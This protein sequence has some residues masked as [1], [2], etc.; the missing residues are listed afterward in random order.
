LLEAVSATSPSKKH[1]YLTQED[2][3]VYIPENLEKPTAIALVS[4][5]ETWSKTDCISIQN[6]A[7]QQSQAAEDSF[8]SASLE[9]QHMYNSVHSQLVQLSLQQ[10]EID[11]SQL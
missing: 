2:N 4:C 3:A 10:P 5:Q 9:G 8:V 11:Q 7:T 6:T 1:V